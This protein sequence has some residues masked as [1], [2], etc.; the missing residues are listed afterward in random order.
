[1][2]AHL[3]TVQSIYAAFARGDIAAILAALA[4]DC[5]WEAWPDNA[6]QQAGVPWMAKRVGPAG[7]LE[8]FKIIGKFAIHDFKVLSMMAGDDQVAVCCSI[9]ATVPT[10]GK[11]YRDEEIHL[12]TFNAAGKVGRFRHY[13]DTAKHIEVARAER[14][15]AKGR[16]VTAH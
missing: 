13:L 4:A 14:A 15:N 3:S 16:V 12:W 11:R 8:F 6:A 2:S 5:E 7:T 10:T 1:M 9:D